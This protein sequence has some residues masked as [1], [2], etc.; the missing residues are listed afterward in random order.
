M[1]ILTCIN[2]IC[3]VLINFVFIYLETRRDDIKWPTRRLRLRLVVIIPV[4]MHI[5][6][7]IRDS[8]I[9]TIG[10]SFHYNGLE[11]L[12]LIVYIQGKVIN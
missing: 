12:D 8:C 1:Y 2:S 10:E 3:N 6:C 9:Y 11:V 4:L 5:V 7:L